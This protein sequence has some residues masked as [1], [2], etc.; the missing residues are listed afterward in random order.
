MGLLTMNVHVETAIECTVSVAISVSIAITV[1]VDGVVRI[2]RSVFYD[3]TTDDIIANIFI[4]S[5]STVAIAETFDTMSAV[6]L[7][8]IP[9]QPG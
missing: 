1:T 9:V 7:F 2:I 3:W 4:S 5:L 8:P 6:D